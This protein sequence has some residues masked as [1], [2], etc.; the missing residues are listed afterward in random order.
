MPS[1]GQT[2]AG[3]VRGQSGQNSNTTAILA[4]LQA[5]AQLGKSTSEIGEFFD[6]LEYRRQRRESHQWERDRHQ[7]QARIRSALTAMAAGEPIPEG[8]SEAEA[9]EAKSTL[10]MARAQA[11]RAEDTVKQKQLGDAVVGIGKG[12]K[13]LPE[14]KDKLKEPEDIELVLQGVAS[15]KGMFVPY[16]AN[17][18]IGEPASAIK[19]DL[20]M[21]SMAKPAE[22]ERIMDNIQEH[23]RNAW[24]LSEQL[25]E[26]PKNQTDADIAKRMRF[27]NN[28]LSGIMRHPDYKDTLS[29]LA[30]AGVAEI[31]AKSGMSEDFGLQKVDRDLA[32]DAVR[33]A[34]PDSAALLST[35]LDPNG[36]IDR[37]YYEE[38]VLTSFGQLMANPNLRE[39]LLENENLAAVMSEL[40]LGSR[41]ALEIE[42]AFAGSMYSYLKVRP[43]EEVEK[44]LRKTGRGFGVIPIPTTIEDPQFPA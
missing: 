23:F 3:A 8:V 32:I 7:R 22:Q 43:S 2:I 31:A 20:T 34:E 25:I 38:N 41:E 39:R 27:V 16:G 4:F 35:V 37:E 29:Q 19:A 9:I 10:A 6:K 1:L 28:K 15:E 5:I 21:L 24:K 40:S 18:P 17:E 13:R 26:D 14:F 30:L 42:P 12:G 33:N 36:N 44:R 11:A